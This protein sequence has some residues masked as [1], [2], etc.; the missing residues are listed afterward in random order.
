MAEQLP[1]F[2]GEEFSP[3][4]MAAMDKA[5]KE[6]LEGTVPGGQGQEFAP[7]LK[8]MPPIPLKKDAQVELNRERAKTGATASPEEVAKHEKW[9][10]EMEDM[11]NKFK[12]AA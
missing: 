9:K 10:K 1:E 11:R 6:A 4:Q 2:G 7:D 3:E 8:N 12:K 5:A